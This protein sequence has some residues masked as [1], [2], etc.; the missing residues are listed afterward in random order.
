MTRMM[1]DSTVV[2]DIPATVN[3][4]AV[5]ASGDYQAATATV[6]ARFPHARYGRCWIDALGTRPDA[7]VR[8]WETGD[9]AGSLEQWVIDHNKTSGK[10]DATVY[11]NVSTIPEVR[12]LT[13]AQVL[14]TDY[15]LWIATL[16]G[17]VVT[18][19]ADHLDSAPYT[20]PGVVA[21]QVKG[22]NLTG[23]HWDMSM[24]YDGTLWV[25][26]AP[27]PAAPKV[28]AASAEEALSAIVSQAA[29]L[30]VYLRQ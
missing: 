26:A 4:A 8:D 17:T 24:V 27:A 1:G 21:C 2:A 23:G 29:V 20:Y 12:Q 11:C 30:G 6:E 28:S 10:K 25:P 16:D 19:G 5:Y 7:N 9:K 13:G 3:I 14:G 22:Q 18:A 15:W